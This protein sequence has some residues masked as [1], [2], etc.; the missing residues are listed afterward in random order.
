MADNCAFCGRDPYEYVD[1]G[2]GRERVAVTCCDLGVAVYDHRN[3]DDTMIEVSSAE[4]RELSE[5]ILSTAWEIERRDRLIG[6]LY[7]KRARP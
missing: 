6:K 7:S 5:R 3:D 1:I 2:V 4:L